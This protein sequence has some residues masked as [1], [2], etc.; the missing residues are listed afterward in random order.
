MALK[1]PANRRNNGRIEGFLI[2][3]QTKDFRAGYADC[4]PWS[5]FGDESRQKLIARLKEGKLNELLLRSLY[6]ATLDGLARE[7]RVSLFDKTEVRSHYTCSDLNELTPKF[8]ERLE[9][10]GFSTIKVKVGG[11][12]VKESRWL[13]EI[14]SVFRLRLDFNGAGGSEF[15]RR[16]RSQLLERIEYVEDPAPFSARAWHLLE[17]KYDIVIACDEPPAKPALYAGVRVIKPARTSQR[18]RRRDVLTNSMD[19]PV[20]QSFA[21]WE[22]QQYVRGW[23]GQ[24]K[25]FGLKTAHLLKPN[26]FTAEIFDESPYFTFSD[27]YGIGFDKLLEKQKW[28]NL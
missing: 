21:F 17:K 23:G 27:G 8:L 22:A 13:S 9:E 10:R 19:H 4:L 7:K 11:D 14:P 3:L 12:P 1:A 6:Y 20:G 28:I 5:I 24:R 15:L 25:D 18:L 2:R 16:S 26:A